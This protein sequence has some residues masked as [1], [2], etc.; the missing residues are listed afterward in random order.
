[1][2]ERELLIALVDFLKTYFS[3]RIAPYDWSFEQ[4]EKFAKIM[5]ILEDSNW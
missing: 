3:G 1:M 2:S 5:N 4:Q